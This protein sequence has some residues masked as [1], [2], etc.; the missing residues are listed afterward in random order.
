V[1]SPFLSKLV[2][3][4]LACSC[5]SAF[6]VFDFCAFEPLSSFFFGFAATFLRFVPLFRLPPKCL[7]FHSVCVGPSQR[8]QW[9]VAVFTFAMG[10]ERLGSCAS[11]GRVCGVFVRRHVATGRCPFLILPEIGVLCSMYASRPCFAAPRRRRYTGRGD[12]S[13]MGRRA[14]FFVPPAV[15]RWTRERLRGVDFLFL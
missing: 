8:E 13:S 9:E 6:Q 4:S 3:S 5:S 2:D 10:C 15:S 1:L 12:F 11:G 14:F 7:V